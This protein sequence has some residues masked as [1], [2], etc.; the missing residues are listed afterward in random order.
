MSSANSDG[1]D[2]SLL[3][4]FDASDPLFAYGFECG[5]IWQILREHPDRE[6][7]E[8]VNSRNAEMFLRMGERLGRE[9]KAEICEEDHGW[10]VIRFGAVDYEKAQVY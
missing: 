7:S 1:Y 9:V 6:I 10:M 3:L 8:M 5:R 4:C 2:S